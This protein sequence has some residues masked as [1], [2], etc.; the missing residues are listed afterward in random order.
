[1]DRRGRTAEK[2]GGWHQW[3]EDE[4]R[5]ALAELARSGESVAVFAH[6]RGFSTQRVRYWKKRLGESPAVAAFV[7]VRWPVAAPTVSPPTI[8]IVSGGITLRVR[9][10]LD[11]EH[12]ARIV[13][14]LASRARGC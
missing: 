14:A 13:A 3:T 5:S 9:E 8:E 7:P 1:M 2:R 11:V 12:V 6:S 10:D 4:A